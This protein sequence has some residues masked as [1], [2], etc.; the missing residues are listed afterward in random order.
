MPLPNTSEFETAKASSS[1]NNPFGIYSLACIKSE[2]AYD[3][4]DEDKEAELENWLNSYASTFKS[5]VLEP[6]LRLATEGD[7]WA[8]LFAGECLRKVNE[9]E[10]AKWYSLS[11]KNGNSFAQARLAQFYAEGKGVQ[12]N[13]GEAVDLI[14]QSRESERFIV[15]YTIEN[16][17]RERRDEEEIKIAPRLFELVAILL[18]ENEEVKKEAGRQDLIN[19]SAKAKDPAAGM[20]GAPSTAEIVRACMKAEGYMLVEDV[21][22]ITTHRM[23]NFNMAINAIQRGNKLISSGGEKITVG[24]AVYPVRV[25]FEN[26]TKNEYLIYKN[27]FN[28]WLAE[29]RE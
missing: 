20:P 9:S 3:E 25:V 22:K 2:A 26:G 21:E 10:A 5:A 4:D 16:F 19:L 27:D 8:A 15:G 29:R 23:L 14:R 24:S 1:T 18:S 28:E 12:K 7:P 17:G 6:F 13:I 11:S